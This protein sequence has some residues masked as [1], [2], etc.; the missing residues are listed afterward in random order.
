VAVAGGGA[1]AF[2][3]GGK[4]AVR[5]DRRSTCKQNHISP[6]TQQWDGTQ[7][8]LP[9]RIAHAPLPR[10]GPWAPPTPPSGQQ[11]ACLK[12]R[13]VM[14]WRASSPGRRD[15]SSARRTRSSSSSRVLFVL[16]TNLG[17]RAGK[18]VRDVHASWR[19]ACVGA[20]LARGMRGRGA[21]ACACSAHARV[22]A[23]G[24]DRQPQDRT[25]SCCAG[26]P[27]RGAAPPRPARPPAAAVAA[28]LRCAAASP[29]RGRAWCAA[30][31]RLLTAAP[32]RAGL[33]PRSSCTGGRARR[34]GGGGAQA[35][36]A[37]CSRA[38]MGDRSKSSPP[39]AAT[40]ARCRCRNGRP[41]G[42]FRSPSRP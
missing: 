22:H 18:G 20:P 9:R 29:P 15:S 41:R 21:C 36:R 33:S 16:E 19:E 24:P 5:T 6:S 34:A 39:P 7:T 25:R 40:P 37:P 17:R 42:P 4:R 35:A 1:A 32:R 8:L 38:P 30:P 23:R 3:D 27:E 31:P 28:P 10:L 2:G 26:T 13:S 14:R 12:R 11:R